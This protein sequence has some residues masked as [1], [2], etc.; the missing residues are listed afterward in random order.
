MI[1]MP[2]VE[3]KPCKQEHIKFIA[4]QKGEENNKLVY[5]APEFRPCIEEHFAIS[6]WVGNVCVAAAGI[7]VLYGDRAI[8]WALISRDA[9]PYMRQ[10]TRKVKSALDLHYAKRIE[11]T[12]RCD[13]PKGHKWAKLLGFGEPEA[14][15]MRH[16]GYFGEDEAMYARIKT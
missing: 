13:Y 4:P 7:I 15:R 3:F 11:M 8:G 6:G 2:T 1:C 14:P 9:G 5:L 12:V 16:S 10:I